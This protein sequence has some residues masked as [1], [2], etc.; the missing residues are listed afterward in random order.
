MNK[1]WIGI[2]AALLVTACGGKGFL[3]GN[4]AAVEQRDLFEKQEA[5]KKQAQSAE[6]QAKEKQVAE[7]QARLK[8]QLAA[9]QA[10]QN[11][12]AQ[13]SADQGEQPVVTPLPPTSLTEQALK[14]SSAAMNDP[15]N[16][17]SKR[18]IYFG[19]DSI[20][21]EGEYSSIVEAH[22]KFLLDHPQ[23]RVRLEGNCDIRGSREYNLALGQKRSDSVKRAFALLGVPAA[24]I[25]SVSFGEEKP[26]IQGDTEEA[27]QENRRVDIVYSDT[28]K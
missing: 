28:A 11:G 26:R 3:G 12:G 2:A 27:H 25:E 19:Y 21:V 6:Q 14:D 1:V 24:Q 16:P 13:G 15:S 5:E 17:L 22:A 8:A 18:S 20:S 9:Q 7:E 4:Q 10:Q 23:V